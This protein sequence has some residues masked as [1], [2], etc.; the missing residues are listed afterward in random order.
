MQFAQTARDRI[1]IRFA[2]DKPAPIKDP[3]RLDAYL[4][5]VTPEPMEI[6]VRQVPGIAQ[7]PSGK[8]EY[9]TCEINQPAESALSRVR[10]RR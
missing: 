9:A 1:E 5:R 8:Y 3:D 10:R 7:R 6:V 4:R 2:S